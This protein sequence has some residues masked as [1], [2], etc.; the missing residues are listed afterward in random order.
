M[1]ITAALF[2]SGWMASGS[3]PESTMVTSSVPRSDSALAAQVD[4]AVGLAV[5]A[6]AGDR[7]VAH[8]VHGGGL[9]VPRVEDLR[10]ARA[11]QVAVPVDARRQLVGI[12]LE[13]EADERE[14]QHDDRRGRREHRAQRAE[15]V[16][17]VQAE[18]RIQQARRHDRALEPE[19]RQPDV[20]REQHAGDRPERVRRVHAADRAFAGSPAQQRA[21]EQR[22]RHARAEGRRQH[23]QRRDRLSREVEQQIARVVAREAAHQ[24][25]HELEAAVVDGQRGERG[26]AHRDLHPAEQAL[27]A[28][29]AIHAPAHGVAAERKP[30][31]E[32]G[33]HQLERV[34]GGAQHEREHADPGDLV[35]ERGEPGEQRHREQ[36][37]AG[38]RLPI[39]AR[40]DRRRVHRPREQPHRR[41]EAE[42]DHARGAQR[43]GQADP[44][45]EQEA[46]RQ[47]AER[48]AEAVG[49]V[50]HGHRLARGLRER[51]HQPRAHQRKRGAQQH[52]LRQ[53]EQ[54]GEGEL[55]DEHRGVA[56]ERGQE[57]AVGP[58]GECDERLVKAQCGHADHRL[59]ERVAGE[60]VAQAR[61]EARAG[62]RT[63]GHP[64][65]EHRQHQGLRVGRVAEVQLQVVRPDRLVDEACEPG[66]REQQVERGARRQEPGHG[67]RL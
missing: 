54:A 63:D 10:V 45:D 30:E 66:E 55:R 21:G 24:V 61:R 58:L 36:Q 3:A 22:Q 50:E 44:G 40:R 31:D 57:R 17:Q 12:E 11:A 52:R 5:G 18:R 28:G 46:A 64:A 62:G 9:A 67:G 42:V 16:Q 4:G 47:H 15:A 53:D 35:D 33:E 37:R 13:A 1:P 39:R 7:A 60:R 49:E 27:G 20:H 38:A 43:A 19:Q 65:H 14:H 32:G 8:E 34:R 6:D 51:A 48:G 41:R 25:L 59:G 56:A 23:D 29:D 26:E 2:A